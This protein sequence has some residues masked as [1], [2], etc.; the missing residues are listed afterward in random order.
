MEETD[1]RHRRLLRARGERPGGCRA[2]NDIDELTRRTSNPDFNPL[3][4]A[5]VDNGTGQQGR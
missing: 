1:H 4:H 5:S 2:S 3:Q